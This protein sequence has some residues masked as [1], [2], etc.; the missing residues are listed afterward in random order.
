[1]GQIIGVGCLYSYAADIA[2]FI[3]WDSPVYNGF[4]L[5]RV[6]FLFR[7]LSSVMTGHT[8]SN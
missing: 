7:A 5:K 8:A 2:F 4:I 6:D 1:M 3:T